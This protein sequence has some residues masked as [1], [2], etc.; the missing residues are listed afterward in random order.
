MND[1]AGHGNFPVPLFRFTINK[2]VKHLFLLLM[3]EHMITTEKAKPGC[4]N[5]DSIFLYQHTDHNSYPNAENHQSP[6]SSHIPNPVLWSYH[7]LCKNS[8]E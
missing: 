6:K 1:Q 4:D 2:A 3:A 8:A 5:N 7:S